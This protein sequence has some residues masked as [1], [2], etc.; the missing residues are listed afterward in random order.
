MIGTHHL[1]QR[2]HRIQHGRRDIAIHLNQCNR[3][4]ASFLTAQ[5]EGRNIQTQFAEQIARRPDKAR[6]IIIAD[7]EQI[8][9]KIAFH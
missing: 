2:L 1:F 4:T 8:L 7:I 5:M 9:R 3:L 6:L